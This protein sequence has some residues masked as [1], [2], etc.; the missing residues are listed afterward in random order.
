M[1]GHPIAIR[2]EDSLL[3]RV[4]TDSVVRGRVKPRA[5][6]PR[7]EDRGVSVSLA[8]I[9]SPRRLLAPELG[10][11]PEHT[12]VVVVAQVPLDLGLR[13]EH[14]PTDADPGHCLL[15]GDFSIDTLDQ[16]ASASRVADI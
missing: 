16:L 9:T 2:P 8:R 7:A 5:F 12:V 1:A 14:V 15:I 10:G 4:F 11:K 6:K 3:R 13:I